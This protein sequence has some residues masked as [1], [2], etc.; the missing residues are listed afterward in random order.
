M[1]SLRDYQHHAITLVRDAMRT[2][3][4]RVVLVL[5]TGAGKTRTGSAIVE[6][7]VARGKRVV[8][9]AHRTEL[10]EQTAKAL[11]E[12]GLPVG[13]V[14]ASALLVTPDRKAERARDA[15]TG[16][17]ARGVLGCSEGWIWQV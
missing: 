2:G 4:R 17:V 6:R 14:A 3:G 9:L 5:P 10:V 11:H 1:I 7:S 15:I 13:V 16:L 8:W 12:H